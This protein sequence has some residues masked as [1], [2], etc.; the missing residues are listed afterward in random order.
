MARTRATK[1]FDADRANRLR[2]GAVA[3]TFKLGGVTFTMRMA[4]RPDVIAEADDLTTEN[5][6]RATIEMIDAII[7]GFMEP[8]KDAHAKYK[9]LR[10]RDED[11]LTLQDLLQVMYWLVEA[12]TNRPTGP[13]SPSTPG[14]RRTTTPSTDGSRS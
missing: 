14:R 12:Y 2:T 8:E 10:E 11:P 13:S 5:G 4:V 3:P 6:A 7:L 9:K 1:D